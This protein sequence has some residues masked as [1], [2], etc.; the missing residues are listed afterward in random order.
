MAPPLATVSSTVK[1]SPTSRLAG[2]SETALTVRS[3]RCMFTVV[4][5]KK[6]LLVSLASATVL[7]SSAQAASQ[8]V[9][10]ATAAGMVTVTVPASL[11]SAPSARTARVPVSSGSAAVIVLSIE[12]R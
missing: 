10:A 4:A 5:E 9:P 1:V 3:A 6:Q 7:A 12:K 8:Y 11:S 2:G